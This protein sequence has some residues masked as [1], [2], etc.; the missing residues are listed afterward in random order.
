MTTIKESKENGLTGKVTKA[1]IKTKRKK[2][3]FAGILKGKIHY[4][5]DA[6]FNLSL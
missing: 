4:K 3:G 1:A 5:S 2:R 6:I